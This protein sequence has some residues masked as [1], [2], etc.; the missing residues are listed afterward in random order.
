MNKSKVLVILIVLAYIVFVVSQ[1]RGDEFMASSFGAVIYPIIAI[2]YFVA[3]KKKTLFFSLFLVFYSLSELILF[4]IDFMPYIYYYYIGN[5]LVVISYIFLLIEIC[6][7]VCVVHVFKNFKIHLVVLTGLNIYIA[8]I[9][10]EVVNPYLE[11]T[12]EYILE[13]SY[14]IVMLLLLS[15]SLLNYLY[16]DNKKTLFL[17][18]GTLCIVF[19]EVINIAYLYV[20]QINLLTVL[21]TSL[22]LLAFF[23]LYNQSKLDNDVEQNFLIED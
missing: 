21:S 18:I 9:L 13:M 3:I 22:F 15:L 20:S 23:F 2:L 12:N 17:F 4:I 5:S 14:N 19:S 1:F 8:Y 11:F 10:Q 7:S 16:K 6:Q